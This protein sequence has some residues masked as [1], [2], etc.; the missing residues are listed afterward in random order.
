MIDKPISFFVPGIPKPGGSK[1]G[2]YNKELGRVLITEA[3]KGSANWRSTVALYARQNY[4]GPPLKGPLKLEIMFYMP[5]PKHHFGTGRN[6]DKLKPSA[7]SYHD[8]MPDAT[9]LMRSTED[10]LKGI[11]WDDDSQVALQTTGKPYSLRPGAKITVKPISESEADVGLEHN[12]IV[13]PHCKIIQ[14]ATP[15]Q[16]EEV[17]EELYIGGSFFDSTTDVFCSACGKQIAVSIASVRV[18]FTVE[19]PLEDEESPDG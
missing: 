8:V 11:L 7:P 3:C 9:K 2:F 10:A 1:D 18:E 13:C 14:A 16:H 15:L 17:I 4:S 12:Q 5:R 19:K 6:A